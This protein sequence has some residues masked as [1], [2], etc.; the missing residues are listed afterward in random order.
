MK[1]IQDYSFE[2]GKITHISMY[3][4]FVE[5]LFEQWNNKMI[6]LRFE[7]Y[8]RI[9]DSHSID[10]G[11]GD[12][13]I[14]SLSSL[15]NEVI[16]DIVDGSGSEEEANGLNS[17]SFVSSWGDRVLFEIVARNVKVEELNS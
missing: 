6:R 16:K 13:I 3:G 15:I 14:S 11:V 7:E 17:Y 10:E 4:N 8:W 12:L 2:D 9:K 1:H 5:L